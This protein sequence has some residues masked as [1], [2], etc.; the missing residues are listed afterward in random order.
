MN[1][2]N[3]S[4]TK[5][6][7]IIALITLLACVIL[8]SLDKDTHGFNDLLKPGNLFALVFYFTPTF[9]VSIFLY[10]LFSKKYGGSKSLV[11]SLVTGIPVSFT[12]V[13]CS[14]LLIMP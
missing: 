13:I 3:T 5:Q 6:F 10:T 4:T 11:L 8:F 9:L 12:L 2:A 7:S 1:M 14:F